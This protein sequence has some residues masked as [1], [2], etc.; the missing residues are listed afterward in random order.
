[1]DALGATWRIYPAVALVVAGAILA[2]WAVWREWPRLR[3]P[4]T[5]RRK[6][7]GLA[8]WLRTTIAGLALVAVG[9]GWLGRHT[10]VVGV[11][12]VILGEEMLETSVVIA[13]LRRAPRTT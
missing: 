4:V 13:A 11:A 5:D 8:C 1:M 7:L 10:G 9:A 12:L 2:A 3:L 6:A